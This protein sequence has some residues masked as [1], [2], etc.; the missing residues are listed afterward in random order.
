M[1]GYVQ[2][3]CERKCSP[4]QQEGYVGQLTYVTSICGGCYGDCLLDAPDI[5]KQTPTE[6]VLAFQS[7]RQ[8]VRPQ[9]EL[10]TMMSVCRTMLRELHCTNVFKIDTQS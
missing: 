7:L 1:V 5:L 2:G 6:V 9:L 10:P 4:P 3:Y 8:A